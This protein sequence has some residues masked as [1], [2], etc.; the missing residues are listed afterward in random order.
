MMMST[1]LDPLLR[2]YAYQGSQEREGE[3]GQP[4]TIDPEIARRVRFRREVQL[5]WRYITDRCPSS[6]R[7]LYAGELVQEGCRDLRI[8]RT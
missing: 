7:A 5:R 1:N 2:E 4:Q 3:A 6:H 8:V